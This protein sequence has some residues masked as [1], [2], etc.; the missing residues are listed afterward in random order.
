MAK[1]ILE[2][3]NNKELLQE[4]GERAKLIVKEYDVNVVAPK[5]LEC[6]KDIIDKNS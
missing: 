6:I 4:N 3:A 1:Q 5:I 2:I